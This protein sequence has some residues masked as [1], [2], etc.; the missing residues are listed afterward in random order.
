[1]KTI[2]FTKFRRRASSYFDDVERGETILIMRNGKI[3]ARISPEPEEGEELAW[4]QP[5]PRLNSKDNTLSDMI[6]TDR[7]ESGT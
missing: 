3:I 4:Q 7:E 5:G 6:R 1:M 2:Q